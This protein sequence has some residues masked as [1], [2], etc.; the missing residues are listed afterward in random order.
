MWLSILEK[1]FYNNIL[2][3]YRKINNWKKSKNMNI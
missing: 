1:I 3:Y 2:N